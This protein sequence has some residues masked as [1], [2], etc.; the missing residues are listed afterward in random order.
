VVARASPA[1]VETARMPPGVIAELTGRGWSVQES[2]SEESGLHVIS[3][4]PQGLEG[5]ADPRREGIVAR[6]PAPTP[7][8]AP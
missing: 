6:V 1:R 7:A 3:V 8:P 2:A 5:A 4:T